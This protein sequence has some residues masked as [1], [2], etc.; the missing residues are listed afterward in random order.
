MDNKDTSSRTGN[1][2]S[3]SCLETKARGLLEHLEKLLPM[4]QRE[5]FHASSLTPPPDS[6]RLNS[7]LAPPESLKATLS[8]VGEP[9]PWCPEAFALPEPGFRLGNSLEYLLGA[10]YI[11]TKAAMLAVEV[12]EPLPGERVLDMA[13]SPGGKSTQ[14]AAH[15]NN[16]GLLVVNEPQSRRLPALV[17]NLERCGVANAIL[18]KA[19]GTMMAR[20]FHNY[21]DR[22]MLDA[23]CS[24]DGVLRKD[25]A[26]LRYWS[27]KDARRQAQHQKGLLRAAFHML[28]PGGI[29]VYST[30][31]LSLEEN[32][33][34]LLGL[35]DK[36]PNNADLQP[37]NVASGQPLPMD[38]ADRFPSSLSSGV[39]IW[40]HLHDTEGAFVVRVGKRRSTE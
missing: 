17:G 19:P 21:F 25:R 32:E 22:V 39:R 12:L 30:C 7:I 37:I 4:E 2:N 6:L 23:P 9:V 38:V 29:L 15:M 20:Y 13:A 35:L 28:R 3:D 1:E 31:S 8:R 34:V 33:E 10:L 36:N 40:P 14:I 5:P 26:M 27:V 16:R 11:Q 18:S 24:G